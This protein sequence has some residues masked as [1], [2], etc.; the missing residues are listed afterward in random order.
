MQPETKNCQN[1][2]KDFTIEPEDFN[3]YEKIK[4]PPPTWCPECRL[5]RRLSCVNGWSLFWRNCDKC[6]KRT[7]S[8][9][10]PTQKITVYCQ[11]CWWGD[12]WDGTEYAMDYDPNRSF[13]EQL[14]ELSE[15]TPYPALETSYLTIKNSEY[16]NEIAH[17]KNCF[18]VICA[19]RCESVY[20]SSILNG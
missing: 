2:K 9:F 4:V 17:S 13:F 20:Y 6:G 1:C 14:K 3:Y 10:P 8:A 19:D 16:S 5:I 18:M 12:S 15:K 7:L 11:P